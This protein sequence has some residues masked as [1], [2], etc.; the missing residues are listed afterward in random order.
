Q[1]STTYSY[2]VAAYDKAGNTS[3]QSTAVSV[4]TLADT[5]APSVPTGLTAAVISSTQINLSWAASTDPD[6]AVAGY[7]IYRN[8][9]KVG[10]SATTSYQDTK[11]APGTTY[12]YTVA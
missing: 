3:A 2:T 6:S 11:V 5:T 7:F 10:S 4:T 8:A 12:S 9:T 1:P